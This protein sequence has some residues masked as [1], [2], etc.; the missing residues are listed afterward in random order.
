MR[1]YLS[2][3]CIRWE[4]LSSD[5]RFCQLFHCRHPAIVSTSLLDT[6]MCTCMPI[7]LTDFPFLNK[8]LVFWWDILLILRIVFFTVRPTVLSTIGMNTTEGLKSRDVNLTCPIAGAPL[9]FAWIKGLSVV[10]NQPG[11]VEYESSS[12]V[13]RIFNAEVS[14]A[15][16]YSCRGNNTAGTAQATV[17]LRVFCKCM[18]LHVRSMHSWASCWTPITGCGSDLKSHHTS[19]AFII[20]F[21]HW[22]IC[23]LCVCLTTR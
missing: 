17:M 5:Y 9:S 10:V 23:D 7:L 3:P 1:G 8:W 13:L 4:L 15:G 16:T 20:T 14:D 12:N 2:H 18:Q 19:H 22:K 6:A 21:F 11:R